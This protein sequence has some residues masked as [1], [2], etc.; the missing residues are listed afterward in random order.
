MQQDDEKLA[1]GLLPRYI[2][3]RTVERELVQE[4]VKL[5]NLDDAFDF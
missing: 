1:V 4:T 3:R 2:N 5:D